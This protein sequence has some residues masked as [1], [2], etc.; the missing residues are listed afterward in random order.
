MWDIY[1]PS[2]RKMCTGVQ[3]ILRFCLSDLNGC[4]VGTADKKELMK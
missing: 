3:A 1:L 2:F 4:N